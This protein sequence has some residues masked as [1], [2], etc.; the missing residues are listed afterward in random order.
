MKGGASLVTVAFVIL[1]IVAGVWLVIDRHPPEWDHANHLERAVLCARDLAAGDVSSIILRSAFYPPLVPCLAGLLSRVVPSDVAAAQ[2]VMLGF[3]ALGMA[4]IYLIG[5]ERVDDTTGVMAAVIFGSAPFVVFNTV[6]FQLDLPLTAI[7]ALAC[8]IVLRVD[9]FTHRGWS[10]A[11]GAVVGLGLL[12]K[13]PFPVYVV[14]AGMWAFVTGRGRGRLVNALLATLTAVL[15]SLA[16]YG[17]RLMGMPAQIANRSF[18]QA[19]ESGHPDPLSW[20][21]LSIYPVTLSTFFGA[22][23]SILLVIGLV[24]A[25]RRRL[26]LELA[27]VLVPFVLFLAIQNKNARYTLPI[28]PMASVVAALALTAL[29]PRVRAGVTGFVLVVAAVQRARPPSRFRPPSGFRGRRSRRP[30]P[31]RPAARTGTIAKS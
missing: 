2:T 17:P 12:T 29:R 4:A 28:L 19:A 23:A 26:W 18:K 8:W 11:L 6:R 30:F 22:A 27:S 20:T 10:L 25:W 5:R 9:G 3:L 31:R 21:A 13:P 14:P 15:V 24:V 1:A 7:V 16:W